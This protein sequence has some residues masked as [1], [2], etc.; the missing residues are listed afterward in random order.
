MEPADRHLDA[1]GAELR[2]E[3]DRAGELVRLHA[4]QADQ[5]GVGRL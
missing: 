2:G 3:V 5:A 1:G 4:D